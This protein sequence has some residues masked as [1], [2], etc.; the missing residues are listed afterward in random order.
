MLE[1]LTVFGTTSMNLTV[2][3]APYNEVAKYFY[4]DAHLQ[5]MG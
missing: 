5:Y 1:L 4:T 2:F 3:V